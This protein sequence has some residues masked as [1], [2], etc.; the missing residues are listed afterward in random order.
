MAS[1]ESHNYV[2]LQVVTPMGLHVDTTSTMVTLAGVDGDFGVLEGHAPFFTKMRPGVL[3]YDEGGMPRAVAVSAG[4]V[5]VTHEKIVV[6]ART[7]EGPGQI[8]EERARKAKTET[9]ERLHTLSY[10]DE[11]RK[12]YEDKLMRANAR[13]EVVGGRKEYGG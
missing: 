10:E 9:E 7:C 6:L 13:L 5:E 12:S 3:R 4:F 1:P 11:Q 2:K 8:D